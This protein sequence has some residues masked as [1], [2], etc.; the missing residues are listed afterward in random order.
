MSTLGSAF[1]KAH[2]KNIDRYHRLLKTRLSEVER[3]YIESRILTER[4]ALE[5]LGSADDRGLAATVAGMPGPQ[6]TIRA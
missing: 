5:A 6:D 2:E 3:N 4:A 1:A